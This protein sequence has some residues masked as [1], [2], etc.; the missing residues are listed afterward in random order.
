MIFKGVSSF[1]RCGFTIVLTILAFISIINHDVDYLIFLNLL[2]SGVMFVFFLLM[3]FAG[4]L[5]MALVVVPAAKVCGGV[6]FSDIKI[7]GCRSCVG[8]WH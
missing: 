4:M 6:E 5:V 2:W 7:L 8:F 3:W 1:L